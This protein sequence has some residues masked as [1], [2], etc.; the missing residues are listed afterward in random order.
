MPPKGFL[1]QSEGPGGGDDKFG[2]LLTANFLCLLGESKEKPVT[3]AFHVALSRR[4]KW[5]R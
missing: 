3:L 2:M 5:K 4:S 1:I